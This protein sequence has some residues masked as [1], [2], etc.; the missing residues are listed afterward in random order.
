M[1]VNSESGAS[2]LMMTDIAVTILC[3][4]YRP[5]SFKTITVGLSLAVLFGGMSNFHSALL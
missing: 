3:D 2:V 5:G 1:S 4:D